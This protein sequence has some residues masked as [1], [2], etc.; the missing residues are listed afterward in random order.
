MKHYHNL[1]GEAGRDLEKIVNE[2]DTFVRYHMKHCGH[3]IAMEE[4]WDKL[5]KEMSHHGLVLVNIEQSGLSYVPEH[6]KKGIEG[7]PTMIAYAK[8]GVDRA[9]YK[10]E[11]TAKE[12]K[13]WLYDMRRGKFS[14]P[15]GKHDDEKGDDERMYFSD[16]YGGSVKSKSKSRT[17]KHIG[18]SRK[19]KH[20]NKKGGKHANKHA[21]KHTNKKGGKQTRKAARKH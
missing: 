18:G 5:V 6:L 20:T 11:R 4:E 2:S 16:A 17:L 9:E 7:F 21:N 10:G 13:K 1:I 8:G 3:C 14:K 19:H 12:M 15:T